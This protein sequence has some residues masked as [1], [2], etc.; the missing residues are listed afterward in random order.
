MVDWLLETSLGVV[1]KVWRKVVAGA[2]PT[3]GRMLPRRDDSHVKE[4]QLVPPFPPLV[5]LSHHGQHISGRHD[6]S[7]C[8]VATL[9][10]A[11]RYE[12]YRCLKG[13]L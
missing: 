5:V 1:V 8:T 13:R 2:F 12:S 10:T 6:E 3:C 9:A 4:P 7:I 11:A